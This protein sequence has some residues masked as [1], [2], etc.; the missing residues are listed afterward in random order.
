MS[1][2]NATWQAINPELKL[3]SY[4]EP[5]QVAEDGNPVLMIHSV[6]A[7]HA[8]WRPLA[9]Q[10][11]VAGMQDI[12]AI[13]IPEICNGST[14]WA[15][16]LIQLHEAIEFLLANHPENDNIILTAFG[17]GGTLA[18]EYWQAWGDEARLAYLILIATPH[19]HTM[20]PDLTEKTIHGTG[21]DDTDQNYQT[22]TNPV[23]FNRIGASHRGQTI[24]INIYGTGVGLDFDG[25]VRSLWL[26]EAV[27]RIFP[28]R[29]RELKKDERVTHFILECLRGNRYQVQL[30][31]VGLQM[32]RA[33]EDDHSGP[34]SFD[35][36]GVR[37]PPDTVFKPM[38]DRLY[39]F[40][41][42][43][44]P[45]CTLSYPVSSVSAMLTLHLRDLSQTGNRRRRMYLRLHTPL[46]DGHS[47]AHTMQDSEGSDF[48][49]RVVCKK[50]PTSLGTT[51]YDRSSQLIRF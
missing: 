27:N 26:P 35:V 20:F 19:A 34:V 23:D 43:V 38:T 6:M 32:R 25:V 30:K 10:L 46:I 37:T 47:T 29:H 36:E 13:D 9:H 14:Y 4:Q 50:M 15:S 48:L 45:I 3:Y 40:E 51:W 18:Y 44:P 1:H 5:G 41:E 21:A 7:D 49:W 33:D 31:L 11:A 22:Y 28:L 24:V 2:T 42:T 8:S 17:V 16:A 12:Y 39:L